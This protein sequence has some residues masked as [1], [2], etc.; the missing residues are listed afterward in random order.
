MLGFKVFIKENQNW[1]GV[2]NSHPSLFYFL[3]WTL[4]T[5][6]LQSCHSG[7]SVVGSLKDQTVQTPVS[8]LVPT[9]TSPATNPYYSKDSQ[10]T[11]SGMCMNDYTVTLTGSTGL[12]LATQKCESS[13]FSFSVNAYV[14]GFYSYLVTQT[15]LQNEVSIPTSMVWAR[16]NS[17]STPVISNPATN[18]YYS[19]ASQ[20]SIT[21]TCETGATVSLSGD[22]IGSTT[23]SSSQFTLVLPKAADG[24]YN[25]Q[26]VQTD[27]AGNTASQ[28]FVWNKLALT[29]SPL[30]PTLQV[31]TDQVLTFSGGSGSYT[32]TVIENQSGGTY[33]STTKTYTTGT[34]ANVIDRFALTDSLGVT[35]NFTIS[36]IAGNVD[37]FSYA[38]SGLVDISGNNQTVTVGQNLASPFIAKVVDRYENPISSY[39]VYLQVV[40]GD[41]HIT[42]TVLQFSDLS[43]QVPINVRAGL[44]HRMNTVLMTS[45]A[46]ILPDLAGTGRTKL[47]FDFMTNA[48]GHGLMGSTFKLG[49]NPNGLVVKDINED[50]ILDTII[51]NSGDPSLG[52]LL[53]SGTGSG[54]TAKGSG[55][56]ASMTKV[57][58]ICSSPNGIVAGDLNSD[59]HQDIIITCG[60]SLLYAMQVFLGNGDGTFQTAINVTIDPAENIP[61]TLVLADFDGDGKLDVASSLAGSAKVSVRR[62]LGTG[63]FSSAVLI[64]VGSSPA[65]IAVGDFDHDGKKDIVVVNSSDGSMSV[66]INTTVGSNLSFDNS[67]VLTAGNT[68]V[69][70]ASAD[71]NGDSYDDIVILNTGDG[72]VSVQL[73]DQTGSFYEAT[74]LV[75]GAGATGLVVKDLNGDSKFD[76][77]V[78]NS[79]DNNVSVYFGS[80]TGSAFTSQ[81]LLATVTNP[82]AITSAEVTGDTSVDLL[83]VGFGNRELQILAGQSSGVSKTFDYNISVNIGPMAAAV[84]DFNKD[85]ITDIAVLS[86][87][88]KSIDLLTGQ[89]N[90]LFTLTSSL[91]TNDTSTAVLAVDL[92][93]SGVTDLIAVNNTKS[94][95]RV[96]LNNNDGTFAAPSD[97]TV[98]SAPVAIST[99]DFNHDG[100]PDVVVVNNNSN[101]VSVLL[102]TGTGGFLAK[103]DYAVGGSPSAVDVADLNNDGVIDLV[104]TNQSSNSVSVLLGN[105]NGTFQTH[106]DYTV[107]TAPVAV[108]AADLN[109]D[110]KID[111]VTTNSSEGT[112]SV[113]L[114]NGDGSLRTANQFAAGLNPVGLVLGDFTGDNKLD[115]AVANGPNNQ[116]TLLVGSGNGQF[117][118]ST[119]YDT[120]VL[121]ANLMKADFNNDGQLDIGTFDPISNI[122]KVWL[123]H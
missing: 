118:S 20:I 59:G 68:P 79:A 115:L 41:S 73:N 107:G 77:A 50:G 2:K 86:A 60:N 119:T 104:V 30:N 108:V 22:G 83:V 58:S 71:M 121:T 72:A 123:G 43:G 4:S 45:V 85:G 109:G 111:V 32:L 54:V 17:V 52:I 105:G 78:T 25:I 19:A 112:L 87:G 82:V 76:I 29:V 84:A 106:V 26:V 113:L 56:F 103:Q 40:Q 47:A 14:D 38:M 16:K 64:D 21:G 102:G 110:G 81:P 13:S 49:Q 8:V 92:R 69:A 91:N 99:Q 67:L 93:S 114:G 80:G 88:S 35:Q 9:I 70:V 6:L 12:S 89:G 33:N 53:G 48:L 55:L 94:Q 23:C 74:T 46:G 18:P 37:H 1:G 24:N 65:G 31:V 51:L 120:G 117:N 28:S 36:T 5:L 100:I 62:G 7:G 34:L 97:I 44:A 15:N 116:F 90:G 11:I 66:L 61:N 3:M 122:F 101:S 75:T 96:F 95:V 39:P 57:L 98:G 42:N 27:P 10:L 63:H